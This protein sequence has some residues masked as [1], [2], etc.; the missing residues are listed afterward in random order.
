MLACGLLRPSNTPTA[1]APLEPSDASFPLSLLSLFVM[2]ISRKMMIFGGGN[3]TPKDA[4]NY[5]QLGVVMKDVGTMTI[6]VYH[7]C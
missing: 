1:N 7:S 2:V 3:K 5:G 6:L 4:G